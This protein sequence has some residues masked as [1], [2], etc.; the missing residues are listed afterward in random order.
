MESEQQAPSAAVDLPDLPAWAEILWDPVVALM[1]TL[2]RLA[3]ENLTAGQ[4]ALIASM[5]GDAQTIARRAE[6]LLDRS[7]AA[8]LPHPEKAPGPGPGDDPLRC[9]VLVVDDDLVWLEATRELLS[10][11]FTV[12]TSGDGHEAM[13]VI[14][15]LHPDVV[16]S[17]LFMPTTGGLDLLELARGRD[18]TCDIPFL[19]LSGTSDTETKVK[20][21]DAGAFDYLCKPISLGELVVRI[22][23]AQAHV[24]ALRRER[25]LQET[26]DLTGLPNRRALRG[27]L[28]GAM[29]EAARSGRSLVVAMVDQ[30]GLKRIND[31]YGH[32]VGDESIRLLARALQKCKRGGDFAAR[33]GGDEFVVVM[34]GTDRAGADRFSARVNAEL[35][36][37]RVEVPSEEPVQVSASFG[38]AVLG[39]VA[40]PETWEELLQRADAALYQHKAE[41]KAARAEATARPAQVH[42][43]LLPHRKNG[44]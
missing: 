44:T 30:D 28:Q 12:V 18:D 5:L 17:D 38:V 32:P 3:S 33:L 40:W 7:Q 16:V 35:G 8:S 6:A 1:S 42:L 22:R 14:A 34:P 39:D 29:Q 24:L 9:T 10:R 41:R 19:I 37:H 20:A 4:R 27:A 36:E 2:S 15:R 43:R 21:F 25:H 13:E 26:D 23:N 31:C 11:T